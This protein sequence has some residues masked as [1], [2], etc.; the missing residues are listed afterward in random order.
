MPTSSLRFLEAEAMPTFNYFWYLISCNR[1]RTPGGR[2]AGAAL[3]T[4][5]PGPRAVVTHHN[6]LGTAAGSL[7]K[8]QS[9]RLA[10]ALEPP[11][12]SQNLGGGGGGGQGV[13]LSNSP[14]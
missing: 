10:G 1:Q 5:V 11:P 4:E 6:Y 9:K 14:R 8:K 13:R 2:K 12:T 7:L 3:E